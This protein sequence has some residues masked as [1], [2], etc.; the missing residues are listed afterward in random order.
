MAVRPIADWPRRHATETDLVEQVEFAIGLE[1]GV[2]EMGRVGETCCATVRGVLLAK[3][4]LQY[5]H[6][7][8]EKM[9]AATDSCWTD[10]TED[11]T[12]RDLDV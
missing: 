2:E 10:G 1:T 12:S 4:R 3:Q 9:G 8:T 11:G 5:V 7:A 6:D